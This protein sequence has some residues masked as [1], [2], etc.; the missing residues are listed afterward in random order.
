MHFL[1]LFFIV[2]A[3]F[4]HDVLSQFDTAVIMPVTKDANTY[5]APKRERK[6][7]TGTGNGKIKNLRYGNGIDTVIK[8]I[9]KLKIFNRNIQ[10][11]KISIRLIQLKKMCHL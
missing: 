1:E 2:L 10:L 4:T 9:K 5:V 11:K 8:N 7:D 3:S 6:R